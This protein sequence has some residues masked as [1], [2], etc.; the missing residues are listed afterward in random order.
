MLGLN[1]T[2][3]DF[4][5][6][7]NYRRSACSMGIAK[8]RNGEIVESKYWLIK[9]DPLEVG[10]FQQR[11]HGLTLEDLIR[12]PT[13][14]EQW[15]E[16]KQ[17]L[18]GETLVAHNTSFD[19]SVLSH[20]CSH[21]AID[22]H[23]FEDFCTLK[24]SKIHWKGEISYS[25][26]YLCTRLGFELTHHHAESDAIA[27]AKIAIELARQKE[28]NDLRTID[29]YQYSYSEKKKVKT[30]QPV[31]KL[32]EFSLAKD[33]D[34]VLFEKNIV[35]TG[36]L[37]KF[38]RNDAHKLIEMIGGFPTSG[39][40]QN[41]HVLV[42]GGFTWGKYGESFESSKLKKAKDLIDKGYPIEIL[43]ETD[44]YSSIGI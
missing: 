43:T 37:S 21:Y 3:I 8:V 34:H 38:S 12:Q 32:P 1:F 6:A 42:I 26:S 24:A 7:N 4:E 13:F 39:L 18:N 35:F 16:I 25:L 14:H 29:I 15:D 28:V 36:G 31:A 20:L 17:Y 11:V 27:C 19:I 2:A 5:T 40:T 23:F 30:L 33:P 22:F 41:T 9:P 44:F 10:Y